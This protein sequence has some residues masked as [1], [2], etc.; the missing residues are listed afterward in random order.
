M[1]R[2]IRGHLPLNFNIAN[3]VSFGPGL[4]KLAML[5]TDAVE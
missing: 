3:L 5:K 1:K 2:G 4:M